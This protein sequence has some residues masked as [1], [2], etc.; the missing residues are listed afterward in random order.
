MILMARAEG[1]PARMAIGFLPGTRNGAEH[2][3]RAADAHAWPELYFEGYGWLRFEPTPA[4]RVRSVPAYSVQGQGT[5]TGGGQAADDEEP[6]STATTPIRRQDLEGGVDPTAAGSDSWFGDALTTPQV[7]TLSAVL[8]GLL[9]TLLMP[10][11]AWLVRL[12][13]RR[14]AANRQELIEVEWQ[15]LT[16][17]LR[18]LGL[19]PPPGGTLR[20]WRQHFVTTGHLDAENTKALGRVTATLERARYDRPERTSPEQAAE[21]HRDLK[22]IRRNVSRTRAWKTRLRSMLW[23]STAVEAWRRLPRL[24]T[25]R[26]SRGREADTEERD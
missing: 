5:T 11:T 9:A 2:V 18:D 20:Q 19:D 22:T 26:G 17:T 25:R 24:L 14:A 4:Q 12:R 1:I 23:P 15:E 6:T 13:R 8:V 3:V 21:L 16:T 7:V 10:L